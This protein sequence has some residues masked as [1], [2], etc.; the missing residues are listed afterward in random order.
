MTNDDSDAHG[1]KK[2]FENLY[3]FLSPVLI[4]IIIF[5]GI[6][7]HSLK[8]AS[9]E[10]L[11]IQFKFDNEKTD[12]EQASMFLKTLFENGSKDKLD[13]FIATL[14]KDYGFYHYTD[15]DLAEKLSAKFDLDPKRSINSTPEED[16]EEFER[17]LE[18]NKL[19]AKL[20]ELSRDQKSPFQIIGQKV[21]VSVPARRDQPPHNIAYVARDGRYQDKIIKIINPT[22]PDLYAVLHAVPSFDSYV[23]STDIQ[24]NEEQARAIFGSV[25]T[26]KRAGIVVAK[27]PSE[28]VYD[29]GSYKE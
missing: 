8:I 28:E 1:G 6:Y 14:K 18:E 10:F 3:K 17:L 22:N 9:C 29:P 13:S 16:A 12:D 5:M 15:P 24:L 11:G 7:N 27:N 2:I 26:G 25:G 19:I 23:A 21:R 4:I 20:R